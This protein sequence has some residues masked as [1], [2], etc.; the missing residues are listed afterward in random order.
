ML[1]YFP[2]HKDS[3]NIAHTMPKT[4]NCFK[5]S[6]TGRL[7]LNN[8]EQPDFLTFRHLCITIHHANS[9]HIRTNESNKLKFHVELQNLW[10]F[11]C[12]L[13]PAKNADHNWFFKTTYF[14]LRKR[15][16]FPLFNLNKNSMENWKS[17]RGEGGD[18]IDR[19]MILY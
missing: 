19:S 4:F 8:S 18:S 2:G 13:G 9:H 15:F 12:L 17:W 6:G 16:F 7:I 1:F 5:K 3:R 14:H 10:S 11:S